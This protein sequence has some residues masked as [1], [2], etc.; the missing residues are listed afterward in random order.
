MRNTPRT[1]LCREDRSAILQF[2]G[3]AMLSHK[4]NTPFPIVCGTPQELVQN[5]VNDIKYSEW[6]SQ[7][8][9]LSRIYGDLMPSAHSVVL[10]VGDSDL[11]LNIKSTGPTLYVPVNYSG[12]LV[13]S[14]SHPEY[15]SILAWANAGCDIQIEK[16]AAMEFFRQVIELCHTPG[17]VKTT[18]PDL[19]PLL[20]AS[21]QKVV[22][23]QLRRSSWPSSIDVLDTITHRDK[24]CTFLAACIM[25]NNKKAD[26]GSDSDH[27]PAA[28]TV[29]TQ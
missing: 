27:T 26:S 20:S 4:T 14:T 24:Y 8:I 18:L 17:Q 12:Q 23:S 13:V 21:M 10:L 9:A 6:I 11:K 2:I 15:E 5:L 25:R 29:T 3:D 1:R 19:V 28:Y 16:R 22:L 7:G